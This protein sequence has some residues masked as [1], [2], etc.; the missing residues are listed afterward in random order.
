MTSL[1]L[2]DSQIYQISPPIFQFADIRA[3]S[4]VFYDKENAKLSRARQIPL[5]KPV[6]ESRVL[7]FLLIKL[8][9]I[10]PSMPYQVRVRP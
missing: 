3:C 4:V 10:Q 5:E 1:P 9:S 2:D 7:I 6:S 8:I